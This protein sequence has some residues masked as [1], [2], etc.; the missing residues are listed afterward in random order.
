MAGTTGAVITCPLEVV[1]TRFQSSTIDFQ[2]QNQIINKTTNANSGNE[3]KLSTTT[4]MNDFKDIKSSTSTSNGKSSGDII[5]FKSHLTP[6]YQKSF[7][8]SIIMANSPLSVPTSTKPMAH[9]INNL[10]SKILL[11]NS[12]YQN[13]S[14]MFTSLIK[15]NLNI[16]SRINN[17]PNKPFMR[18]K[19]ISH[20]K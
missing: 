7:N 14:I 6:K 3:T 13:H 18:S 10:N 12:A 15:K 11:H 8:H 2:Y 1:K 20:M 4:K 16:D 9:S 17:K 5:K 19:I